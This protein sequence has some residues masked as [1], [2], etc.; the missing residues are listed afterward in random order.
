M[1]TP[2]TA[3]TLATALAATTATAQPDAYD[4]T[5]ESSGDVATSTQEA[6]AEQPLP[7]VFI[8][9]NTSA[10]Y[11][12]PAEFDET[13]N[14]IS[15]FR[16]NE[17]IGVNFAIGERAR[18]D[19]SVSG[20]HSFYDF[21]NDAAHFDGVFPVGSGDPWDTLHK[22]DFDAILAVQTDSPWEWFVGGG[23]SV[24]IEEGAD[25]D[26]G[27]TGFAVGGASY[28]ISPKLK[29]GAGIA[30]ATRLEEDGVFILPIPSFEWN[31][32]DRWTFGSKGAGVGLSYKATEALVLSLDAEFVGG[33]Y[34]LDD[35]G[36]LANGVV[37]E[38][39]IPIVARAEWQ[40]NR[41]IQLAGFVGADVA[42]EYEL[43]NDAGVNVSDDETDPAFVI[44]GSLS[45]RF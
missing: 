40:P 10:R 11:T 25:F 4:L 17:Q 35:E 19:I 36:P 8:R 15:L 5:A 44:G 22:F 24:G 37:R 18:L 32:S 13:G 20:E 38:R 31:I 29:I 45:L 9:L 21:D 23:A 41:T 43:F 2:L 14:D 33:E 28:R 30:V 16:V 42:V 7:D 1:Q 27:L 3:A 12:A 39:R 34:R 26:D 6:P